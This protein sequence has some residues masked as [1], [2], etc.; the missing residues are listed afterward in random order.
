MIFNRYPIAICLILTAVT[1]APPQADALREARAILAREVGSIAK[2]TVVRIESTNGDFGSGV[3]IGRTERG[4]KNIYTVLTASHVV[5]TLNTSYK[6]VTPVPLNNVGERKRIIINLD[7]QGRV[8]I[9][10]NVDLAVVSFESSH[11]FAVGTI[12]NSEYAS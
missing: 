8:K 12:G 6:I 11:T 9:I 10:P 7:P 2:R 1:I 4:N 5:R 3:I